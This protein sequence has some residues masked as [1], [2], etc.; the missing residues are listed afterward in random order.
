MRPAEERRVLREYAYNYLN[1]RQC[2]RCT[3]SD[4]AALE[5]DHLDP[6]EKRFTI[7]QGIKQGVTLK[8]LISEIKKCQILCANC[9]RKKTAKEQGWFKFTNGRNNENPDDPHKG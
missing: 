4:P 2:V 8:A 1:A 3:E 6:Q 7:S 5:F 9:H